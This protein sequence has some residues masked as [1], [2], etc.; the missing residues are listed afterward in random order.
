[1]KKYLPSVLFISVF[2]FLSNSSFAIEPVTD[3]NSDIKIV[4]QIEGLPESGIINLTFKSKI[5]NTLQPMLINVPNGYTNTKSWPLLVVLHGLGDGPI[6]VPSIDSMVQ[7]GPFGR[8]DMRYH[9]AGEQDVFE[10]IELAKQIFNI[11]SDR[12]YL[13]GF[14]MGGTGTLELGLKYPDIWAACVPVCG[15]ITN[16]DLV[17]NGSNLPFWINTGSED[18]VVPA[19]YSKKAYEKAVELGFKHWKYTEYEGMGHSFWID[20]P[21]IENWLLSQKKLQSPSSIS[22]VSEKTARAYWAEITGKIDKDSRAKI[23][24]QIINQIIQ[25]RTTN[26]SDYN[27]YLG[28]SPVDISREIIVVE[29]NDE[30][31]RG[32]LSED[33]IFKRSHDCKPTDR[34]Q[35][36]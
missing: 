35:V 14:S 31:F 36:Q 20:W 21:K 2:L 27:L 30:I 12:I 18:R 9:D 23:K 19:E 24:V 34:I 13:C 25:V 4:R 26:V 17:S 22:F 11:D 10:C 8:G 16:L 28:F 33:G 32:T 1:M 15:T 29:N 5:D 3:A 7:I 6:V